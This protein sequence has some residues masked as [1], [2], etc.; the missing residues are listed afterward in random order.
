MCT[1][2]TGNTIKYKLCLNLLVI[3]VRI[4]EVCKIYEDLNLKMK[5]NW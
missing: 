4:S 2:F 3:K 1:L 5:E